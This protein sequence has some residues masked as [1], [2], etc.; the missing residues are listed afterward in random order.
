MEEE[1]LTKTQLRYESKRLPRK[2]LWIP[3]HKVLCNEELQKYEFALCK[4]YPLF[5]M[6]RWC[7]TI[8]EISQRVLLFPNYAH[9]HRLHDAHN[10]YLNLIIAKSRRMQVTWW[11]MAEAVH[12]GIFIDY[13]RPMIQQLNQRNVEFLIKDR[14]HFIIK[15]QPPFLLRGLPLR[16]NK[17][18]L[19]ME[20]RFPWDSVIQGVPDSDE[21]NQ[22][23]GYTVPLFICDEAA[24]QPHLH[25]S[26]AASTAALQ[27]GGRSIFLSS[28]RPGYFM[29]IV[30][31]VSGEDDVIV[32]YGNK[33]TY[34]LM[35]GI[36]EYDNEKNGF[37]VL[38]LN[39]SSDPSKD[40]DTPEGKRWFESERKKFVDQSHWNREM[41]IDATA[42][43][44]QLV[45]PQ[46]NYKY[47]V[48]EF[49]Y[50]DIPEEWT[51]YFYMDPGATVTAGLW[52]AVAPDGT[53]YYYDEYCGINQTI[54][55]NAEAIIK[56]EEQHGVKVWIRRADPHAFKRQYSGSTCAD[57]YYDESQ[58]KL[59]FCPANNDVEAGIEKCK[60]TLENTSRLEKVL[61]IDPEAEVENASR[62]YF[63]Y[64]C[65]NIIKEFRR[66]I[67]NDMGDRPKKGQD[68]WMDAWRYGEMDDPSYVSNK[69]KSRSKQYRNRLTG[70]LF[71]YLE[72]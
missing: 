35:K 4:K 46:F 49:T 11:A 59:N 30:E 67:M 54:R 28:V 43:A 3:Q 17:E 66:Y 47:H 60:I 18:L 24:L 72:D 65:S 19:A 39:Y 48:K 45:Y 63:S 52:C 14:C 29:D 51:R 7:K 34:S 32:N 36:D 16:K 25:K 38:M 57:D 1:I 8:D 20:I 70:A 50:K 26:V 22:L 69:N 27:G 40:P 9:L 37:H 68:H 5:W 58:R 53:R 62:C 33:E 64:T 44:D 31:D 41:E 61:E 56:R 15:H 21:G 71:T 42:M 6:L 10:E 55:Q 23:V 2:E 12:M 13:S